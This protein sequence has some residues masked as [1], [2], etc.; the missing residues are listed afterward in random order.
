[1]SKIQ[2]IKTIAGGK[3][4]PAELQNVKNA[5][6]YE[7]VVI[8]GN[9]K[10]VFTPKEG[11]ISAQGASKNNFTIANKAK[12]DFSPFETTYFGYMDPKGISRLT[13]KEVDAFQAQQFAKTLDV[14]ADTALKTEQQKT[15]NIRKVALS[16]AGIVVLI[17]AI[18]GGFYL[19]TRKKTAAG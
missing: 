10:F 7:I 14:A 19:A 9:D 11:K 6:L 8:D 16:V 3:T 2:K 17:S 4:I 12:V 18:A 5:D 13:K 15:L 1:M